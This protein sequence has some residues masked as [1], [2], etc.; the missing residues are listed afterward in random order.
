MTHLSLVLDKNFAI[1]IQG[2]LSI[3]TH[4]MESNFLFFLK[5]FFKGPQN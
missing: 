2:I 4:S 1:W 5:A 3:L